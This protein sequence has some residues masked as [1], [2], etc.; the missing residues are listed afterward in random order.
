LT[1]RNQ[2]SATETGRQRTARIAQADAN[3]PKLAEHL[4]QLILAPALDKLGAKRLLIVADGDLLQIPF[5][6][7]AD[8]AA[9]S[10]QPLIVNHEIVSLPSASVLAVQRQELVKRKPAPKQLA[11]FADPVFEQND[12]RVTA[13]AGSEDAKA[14]YEIAARDV[15]LERAVT[16]AAIGGDRS[17]IHRLPFS[18]AEADAI[19]TF[20]RRDDSLEALDFDASKSTAMGEELSRYRIVHFATHALLN[21]DHP[22]LSGIVLSLVDRK[23]RS[24][25]GF[26]RLN[27]IYNL[28]LSA[29]LVVLSACETGLGKQIKEEGLIGLARGFMGAGAQRVVSSLWKVDDEATAELMGKFYAQMLKE[30]E[31]AAAALRH[32]QLEMSRQNRWRGAYFWA[33]FQ[34]AGEWQ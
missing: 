21:N 30:G 15:S 28:N 1:A 13:M 27:E 33:G 19:L 7:L 22:E 4:S 3:Y 6:V 23:G 5:E 24:I 8:P 11:L 34:M 17:K 26:L 9:T 31:P 14:K 29:D 2:H 16:D 25:D 12:E 18:R 32:A 10:P 20:T